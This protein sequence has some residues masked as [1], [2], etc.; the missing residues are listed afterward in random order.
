MAKVKRSLPAPFLRAA[1]CLLLLQWLHGCNGA[2]NL[3]VK[4]PSSETQVR[5][6]IQHD[7]ESLEQQLQ[8]SPRKPDHL[9]NQLSLQRFLAADGTTAAAAEEMVALVLDGVATGAFSIPPKAERW[10]R[11]FSGHVSQLS[12][13]WNDGGTGANNYLA[14]HALTST[15]FDASIMLHPTL[16]CNPSVATEGTRVEKSAPAASMNSS[17]DLSLDCVALGTVVFTVIVAGV[18]VK[19]ER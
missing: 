18:C 13:V 12:F 10:Q 3:W 4:V 1:C 19:R 16:Q 2:L 15:S 14:M 8:A 5:P 11:Y 9:R 7:S 17:C 6:Q